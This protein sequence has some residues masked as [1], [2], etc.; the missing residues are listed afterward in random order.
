MKGYPYTLREAAMAHVHEHKQ[1]HWLQKEEAVFPTNG[2]QQGF[3]GYYATL[4]RHIPVRARYI[5]VDWL[6]DVYCI[7]EDNMS[8]AGLHLAVQLLDRYLSQVRVTTLTLQCIGAACLCLATKC[9]EVHNPVISELAYLGHGAFTEEELV[10]AEELVAFQLAF[11]FRAYPTTWTFLSAALQTMTKHGG[12]GEGEGEGECSDAVFPF[13]VLPVQRA[14]IYYAEH[15]LQFY[16]LLA[17]R[18]SVRAAACVYTA[19]VLQSVPAADARRITTTLCGMPWDAY[20]D[21]VMRLCECIRAVQDDTEFRVI[22]KKHAVSS[23]GV[24]PSSVLSS[25][26]LSMNG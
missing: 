23:L 18:P 25:N 26:T 16:E 6:A 24:P 1:K 22:A 9:V 7:Y 19:I 8:P 12:E 4:Q 2:E 14:A 13:T 20:G 17:F 15:A 21:C 5:L 11:T 3:H 10:E